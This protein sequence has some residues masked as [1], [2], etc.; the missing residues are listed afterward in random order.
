[1]AGPESG[2]DGGR[3]GPLRR[4]KRNETHVPTLEPCAQVASR[5]PRPHGHQGRPEDHQRPPCAGPQGPERLIIDQVAAEKTPVVGS[6]AAAQG[7]FG[8]WPRHGDGSGDAGGDSATAGSTGV[9]SSVVF[10]DVFLDLSAGSSFTTVVVLGAGGDAEFRVAHLDLEF[11][12][13][14]NL[15]V[16]PH[17]GGNAQEAVE[18]MGREAI[19]HLVSFFE[20][21]H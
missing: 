6:D 12:D 18:A 4:R 15:M 16:T 13:L 14:P 1:M 3:R 5:L 2:M 8:A 17:I 19:Q 10:L 20:N 11:L 21:S 7:S 9:L